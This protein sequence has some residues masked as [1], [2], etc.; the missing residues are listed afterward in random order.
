MFCYYLRLI[1]DAEGA[2]KPP[3]HQ[4]TNTIHKMKMS[5]FFLVN[6][7]S[8]EMLATEVGVNRIDIIN[9]SSQL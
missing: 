3:H 5:P 4:F 7:T 1:L 9:S 8:N 6:F 2:L